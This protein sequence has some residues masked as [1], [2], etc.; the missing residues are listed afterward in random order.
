VY[1]IWAFLILLFMA[2]ERTGFLSGRQFEL[3]A[4][5]E[6]LVATR[7]AL[8]SST[9]QYAP[10]D[11]DEQDLLRAYSL[12]TG[13]PTCSTRPTRVR[14]VFLVAGGI[15]VVFSVLIVTQGLAN[16]QTLFSYMQTASSEVNDITVD[17]LKLIRS[18]FVRASELAS[19][20]S[21]TVAAELEDGEFCPAHPFLEDSPDGVQLRD[22]ATAAL[23]QLEQVGGLLNGTIYSL[24][25]TVRQSRDLSGYVS[26]QLNRIDLTDWRALLVLI[27]YSIVPALLM[28]GALMAMFDSTIDW[29]MCTIN[30]FLLPIF[31]ILV[32]LAWVVSAV[33]IIAA[34]MNGDFCLPGG[35]IDASNPANPPDLTVLGILAEQ[36]YDLQSIEYQIMVY[37]VSQCRAG[38][39]PFL[40]L[41]EAL[42]QLVS[43]PSKF[44]FFVVAK[45][46]EQSAHDFSVSHFL[47]QSVTS[48]SV[49]QVGGL[50][51][52]PVALNELALYCNR[53]FA[54]LEALISNMETLLGILASS[55]TDALDLL[56]CR[57]IVPLYTDTVYQG[58]C[59]YSPQA[60]FWFFSSAL[61]MAVM[62]MIMI[63]LRSSYKRTFYYIPD[64]DDFNDLGLHVDEEGDIIHEIPPPR[65]TVEQYGLSSDDTTKSQ[66]R[67]RSSRQ[68]RNST[69]PDTLPRRPSGS[70]RD[71]DDPVHV[72]AAK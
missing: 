51:M 20:I 32:A 54:G 25:D 40:F 11:R 30:W 28:A 38:N 22:Q 52:S 19:T 4:T 39:D 36:G 67:P 42:P 70:Y 66:R 2:T 33:M 41:R 50:L 3:P 72:Y 43:S 14:A 13:K 18:G 48:E 6:A 34:G 5:E 16:M 71:D 55:I 53:D 8:T 1:V 62:G 21:S 7:K 26:Q 37:F 64:P 15:F 17:G 59:T 45:T 24:E 56:S 46:Y 35:R 12:S 27:P 57:R 61:V 23:A 60:V 29:Y 49:N 47:S 68:S 44:F 10:N 9:K 65:E 31:V 58:M 63:M 69:I